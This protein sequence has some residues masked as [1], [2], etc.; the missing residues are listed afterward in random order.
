MTNQ[1]NNCNNNHWF[2]DMQG[3]ENFNKLFCHCRFDFQVENVGCE[4]SSNFIS[5]SIILDVALRKMSKFYLSFAFPIQSLIIRAIISIKRNM[6]GIAMQATKSSDWLIRLWSWEKTAILYQDHVL[7]SRLTEKR[8][9][10]VTFII[11][12]WRNIRFN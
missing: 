12:R 1:I 6:L 8:W 11:K 2:S 7:K 10:V 3:T 4:S 5:D 9:W